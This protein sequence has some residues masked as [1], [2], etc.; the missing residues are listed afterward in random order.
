MS[1][2]KQGQDQVL[3]ATENK[4]HCHGVSPNDSEK[5]N[6]G[7]PNSGSN[8]AKH[9]GEENQQEDCSASLGVAENKKKQKSEGGP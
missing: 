1:K 6:M 7:A 2:K 8:T 4:T 5:R 3:S 9:Y